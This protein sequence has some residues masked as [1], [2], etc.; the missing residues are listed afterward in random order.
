MTIRI[1]VSNDLDKGLTVSLN[2]AQHHYLFHVMRCQAGDSI[3]LFN[4]KD[5]EWLSVV[6]I[7]S[8]KEVSLKVLENTRLQSEEKKSDVWLCFSPI[9]RDNME[10]IIQKATELGV[11]V[12][13]PVIMRRTVVSKINLDKMKLQAIEASEQ[14][15]RLS[16]PVIN[17]A[18]PLDKLLNSWD[19]NRMLYFLDERN[20]G[21]IWN[22]TDKIAYLVGPEGGFDPEELQK[23]RAL[24]FPKALHLGRRILRAE[25]ACLSVLSVHN[26]LTGWI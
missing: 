23:L 14:C 9:K 17:E 21:D 12:L 16:I 19:E 5:G 3:L 1:F 18:L 25:T 8:K 26:H 10:F 15:E 4:G 20:D 11:S 2:P 22:T 13:Q 24:S 7:I 6:E